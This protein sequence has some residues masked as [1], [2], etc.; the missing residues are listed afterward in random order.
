MASWGDPL[1][2]YFDNF[3]DDAISRVCNDTVNAIKKNVWLAYFLEMSGSDPERW[4][5][6]EEMVGGR[7]GNTIHDRRWEYQLGYGIH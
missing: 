1:K 5:D 2:K 6:L 3:D 4:C 7:Q